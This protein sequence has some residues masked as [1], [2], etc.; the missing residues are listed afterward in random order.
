MNVQ[1]PV[2]V[3]RDVTGS[4]T[5]ALAG[6]SRRRLRMA[7]VEAITRKELSELAAR[8]GLA[9]A[10]VKIAWSDRLV[11]RIARQ[12]YDHR[13]GASIATSHREICGKPARAVARGKS[14]VKGAH[15][16]SGFG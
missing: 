4:W 11:K 15:A 9:V 16:A 13:F 12:G 5:A 2:L 1:Y 14:K 10:G 6:D 7:E 3:W 8:E